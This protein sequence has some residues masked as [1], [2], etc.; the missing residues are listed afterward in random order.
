M[1]FSPLEINNRLVPGPDRRAHVASPN[2]LEPLLP[3][4]PALLPEQ[5]LEPDP[6]PLPDRLLNASAETGT[7]KWFSVAKKYG[8]I[9][10]DGG[11]K[12]VFVHMSVL[13]GASIPFLD[14]GTR[15][16]YEFTQDNGRVAATSLVV[17]A[18]ESD[19]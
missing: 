19:S 16:S 17:L 2:T 14:D 15:V 4:H 9:A 11:G 5:P 8:F 3:P 1:P 12:D 10:P 7:I 13:N 6:L 18:P